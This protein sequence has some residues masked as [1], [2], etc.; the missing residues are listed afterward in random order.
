MEEIIKELEGVIKEKERLEMY[1][2]KI[3]FMKDISLEESVQLTE[4]TIWYGIICFQ[5]Q[6][7]KMIGSMIRFNGRR[8]KNGGNGN[9]R[10]KVR[11]Y[12]ECIRRGRAC[13]VG[14]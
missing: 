1:L 10:D 13:V 14:S 9:G 6:F 5:A 12:G 2:K 11:M 3:P 4:E 7:E 8:R